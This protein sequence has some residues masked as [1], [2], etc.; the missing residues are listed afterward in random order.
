M[1][2]P[3][4]ASDLAKVVCDLNATAKPLGGGEVYGKA[5]IVDG[6][7]VVQDCV[8]SGQPAALCAP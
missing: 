5:E 6:S 7:G 3:L 4:S 1:S 8:D 2:N